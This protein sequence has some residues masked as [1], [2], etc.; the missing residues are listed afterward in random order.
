MKKL[1]ILLFFNII[2]SIISCDNSNNNQKPIFYTVGDSTVKNGKGDGYGGL[3]GWGD[4][5]EQFL[6]TTKVSIE[7]HALGG[8][9]SRTYQALGL[10]DNVY[11]KLKK[12]DYVLIQFGH[13]DNSAVNDTIRARGTIKGIGNETEE[14]DNLITGVHEIVHTYGWYIEKI[15]KD[16]KSKGA[17]PV[18]MSPI[19]RN[20]WKNGKIPRNNTSYGL[21]AKQIADRNDVTFINLND[22]MSTELESF[23]E[24]KVTGTYFYKRDHTHTSAKGAAMASQIIVNELKKLNNSINKYFLDDVDISLPKK[25][26]IF[27]IG[28]STMANNGNENAVGWGV[29]FPEFCDTMQVNVINKARGGRSTRTFIYEGLWNNAKKDFK[30]GDIV[31]I[32]FG[33]NDAGN[34]DKTKFRGSLQGIGNETLQVQRDSIVETVHTFGWYLTKMIQDTKKSGALPVV[35]SLT[36]RNEW[37]NGTVEQRKE[38]Y[39]KW[40]KEVAEKEK[41][42]YIDVSDSVAK[43]YQE[44]GKEKVKDFFPKDHTHTGLNGATFTA[45]TIAE[46]LKKSKEIGLRGVIYLD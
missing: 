15:V 36:P 8:T 2:I 26:N 4:F 42:I 9:S 11:N 34:I 16:A 30:E 44:L 25:Q 22:K 20:V 32:Q 28:D 23:G 38:T 5:L 39:V 3:W 33:H 10:W 19:P 12:G 31:F 35:L 7:N 14:I 29:P 24:S 6:D 46:I 17:I 1:Q 37:P 43:K 13:N 45:K 41:T 21:W 40:A 18:I 27:L